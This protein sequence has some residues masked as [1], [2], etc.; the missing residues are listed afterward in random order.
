MRRLLVILILVCASARATAKEQ[1]AFG[2][3]MES[4]LQR[5]V[6]P[7]FTGL[8]NTPQ[9]YVK[10]NFLPWSA[11][12]EFGQE[13]RDSSSGSL[14]V[15]SSSRKLGVWGRYE[16]TGKNWAPFL[17]SGIGSYFD[18]VDTTFQSSR[19][20]RSGTRKFFG[21]STGIGCTYWE[22]LLLEAEARLTSVEQNKEP[23]FS[24]LFRLGFQI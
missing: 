2:L 24:A 3:G 23:V 15:Q 14:H 7:D 12:V 18:R 19:D 1:W 9:Y 16:F 20:E 17:S 8:T 13:G 22:H 21:L 10:Y 4:R 6:N 5:E 11:L